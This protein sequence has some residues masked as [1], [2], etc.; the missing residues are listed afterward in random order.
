[1][2][3]HNIYVYIYIVCLCVN[4]KGWVWIFQALLVASI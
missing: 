2:Y 4:Y 1:M 3:I